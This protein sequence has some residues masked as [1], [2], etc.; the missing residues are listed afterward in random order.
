MYAVTRYVCMKVWHLS[1]NCDGGQ[2]RQ[3]LQF[4]GGGIFLSGYAG[5]EGLGV[6]PMWKKRE[7]ISL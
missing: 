5:Q 6:R 7:V 2:G 4:T 3:A 1:G